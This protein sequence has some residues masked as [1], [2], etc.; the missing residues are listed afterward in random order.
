MSVADDIQRLI[1]L[2]RREA[3]RALWTEWSPA[4]AHE[5]W[6]KRALR[7]DLVH[8]HALDQPLTTNSEWSTTLDE[9]CVAALA[10]SRDPLAAGR[11]GFSVL[12]VPATVA[13]ARR[14]ETTA[15]HLVD[16]GLARFG[17]PDFA[18]AVR[19]RILLA[20][21]KREEAR[22][23]LEQALATSDLD[24]LH[25][26]YATLLYEVGI[27]ESALDHAVASRSEKYLLDALD[28]ETAIHAARAD[29]GKVLET[30]TAAIEASPNA[31]NVAGRLAHRALWRASADDLAGARSDFVAGIAAI[32]SPDREEREG[33]KVALTYFA[34]RLEALDAATATSKVVRLEAFP[35]VVQK[36]NYCGPAV[37]ELV[38]RHV[39]LEMTQ[40]FI[41]A[42]VKKGDG[43][44]MHELVQFLN[45][46]GI[47]ARRIEATVD[48]TKAALDMGFPVVLE[49]D[50]SAT[51]HVVVAVGYDER[52]GTL[53]IADPGEHA[54]SQRGVETRDAVARKHRF[55]GV[56]VM[57]PRHAVTAAQREDADR[58][59]LVEHPYLTRFDDLGRSDLSPLAGFAEPSNLE[60]AGITREVLVHQPDFGLATAVY[61]GAAVSS[62]PPTAERLTRVARATVAQPQL[63]S[64][65]AATAAW[66]G[67]EGG[68]IGTAHA[69]RAA[70]LDPRSTEAWN[71]LAM[72]LRASG[73]L[74]DAWRAAATAAALSPGDA[75]AMGT[76]AY[77][78]AHESVRRALVQA[79]HRRALAGLLDA[80]AIPSWQPLTMTDGTLEVLSDWVTGFASSGIHDS[81][82]GRMARA[83]VL[84][85]RGEHAA[86]RE[87]FDSA[88]TEVAISAPL[89]RILIAEDEASR[90]DAAEA[91]RAVT[92]S[93]GT[94]KELWQV[95]IESLLRSGN[96][97][98]ARDLA[99]AAEGALQHAT[100]LAHLTVRAE[101]ASSIP[102]RACEPAVTAYALRHIYDG[103]VLWAIADTLVARGLAD[104]A[105]NV[106][107]A[108]VA[109]SPAHRAGLSVAAAYGKLAAVPA[110]QRAQDLTRLMDA[111]DDVVWAPSER[112][113]ALL[114]VDPQQA[115]QSLRGAPVA[116]L[117]DIALRRAALAAGDKVLADGAQASISRALNH[118]PG[119]MLNAADTFI[120]LR[121][122]E[123]LAGLDL[124]YDPPGHY[125]DLAI[126]IEALGK[127]GDSDVVAERL[128]MVG[129]ESQS[130][131]IHTKLAALAGPAGTPLARASL[132]V[133]ASKVRDPNAV[134]HAL[135][136][137][138]IDDDDE[139][140]VALGTND[141]TLAAYGAD[142]VES[143]TARAALL[144]RA[145]HLAPHALLTLKAAH[146][147]ALLMG[148]R[149]EALDLAER[150][151]AEF[152][153]DHATYERLSENEAAYGDPALA[154]E[155][156]R[157]A[158]K[159]TPTCAR[160]LAALAW[161]RALTGE[162]EGAG[163]AA[164]SATDLSWGDTGVTALIRAVI[165][166]DRDRALALAGEIRQW[167][168]G[169]AHEH[170]VRAA[171]DKVGAR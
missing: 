138:L 14:H 132:R 21:D 160:A 120:A 159:H 110:A 166:G 6:Q 144:D 44:P 157:A 77:V 15:L 94:A 140:V 133:L 68:P 51:R 78:L 84:V 148:R 28:L 10:V 49:D 164:A 156:A 74:M 23:T 80:H 155:H 97:H 34:R 134:A 58:A 27:F 118:N 1:E 38:L 37:L 73:A 42:A 116:I 151:L 96:A 29:A 87:V 105:V 2:D 141:G 167:S 40:D 66:S 91:A 54:P 129:D 20:L 61:V 52:L 75:Q 92:S 60:Q 142:S 72:S 47:E 83:Q 25:F 46:Q 62:G 145:L 169:G 168:P 113:W 12:T 64:V 171:L 106:A 56:L 9:L 99:R 82:W 76:M 24:S 123:R 8:L 143:A 119:G 128:H 101:A 137:A 67:G 35:S 109:A 41:A 5:E 22:E 13:A 117:N 36:W 114:E 95:A 139:A 45:E 63:A 65:S 162:W 3:A 32:E 102:E 50:Y 53:T 31:D 85:S 57:G 39:G 71:Q 90:E 158:V 4:S 7:L 88:S 152:P 115:L 43:T 163:H 11:S 131:H 79:P 48:A 104:V 98:A 112:A 70:H 147:D 150:M 17:M 16:E 127:R 146:T 19:G 149:A 59:G 125:L 135:Q 30:I 18:A 26:A 130:P 33:D 55:A 93:L 121:R 154:V 89:M 153:A 124:G 111:Y 81:V 161:A 107:R 136:C 69:A 108:L 100:D 103:D 170:V 86:A 165:S 126:W 122:D